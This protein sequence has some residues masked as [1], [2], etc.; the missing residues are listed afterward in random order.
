[1]ESENDVAPMELTHDVNEQELYPRWFQEEEEEKECRVCSVKKEELKEYDH[2]TFG[3]VRF[4]DNIAQKIIQQREGVVCYSAIREFVTLE[5][6]GT[7]CP[8]LVNC[9]RPATFDSNGN[10]YITMERAELSL[11]N[12]S[13]CSKLRKTVPGFERLS[14]HYVLWSLLKAVTHLNDCHIMHRDIKPGNILVYPGPRVVLCDYGG[15][16]LTHA[17]LDTCDVYMS[18]TVCTKHYSPPEEARG[19]HNIVFDSFSIAATVMHYTMS[20]APMYQ[21][22]TKVNRRIFQKLCKPFPHLLTL[23]KMLC[24]RDPNQ[25]A[26]ASEVLMLFEEVYPH[27]VEKYNRYYVYSGPS[28]SLS[29]P[30]MLREPPTLRSSTWK[31]FHSLSGAVWPCILEG[32]RMCQ[33]TFDMDGTVGI[34]VAFHVLNML[35]HLHKSGHTCTQDTCYIMTLPTI[36]RTCIIMTGSSFEEDDVLEVN[37]TLFKRHFC[38]GHEKTCE[39]T[40]F[41]SALLLSSMPLDW[42]LPV[43]LKTVMGLQERFGI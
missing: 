28:L 32:I 1:M 26:T 37:F 39:Q 8:Q 13:R 19:K 14:V 35:Y 9:L 16:R 3:V 42:V 11:L 17:Q 6:I 15:C 36:I 31:R 41:S 22:M 38:V 29:S 25:R 23:L 10:A 20:N 12:F 40:G 34:V 4:K 5:R 30:R 24:K 7:N 27:L 2:G 33:G 43:D 21:P 18:N